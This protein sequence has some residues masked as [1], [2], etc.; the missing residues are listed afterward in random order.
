M[1]LLAKIAI[2]FTGTL[3][4]AGAYTFREG[5]VRVDVDEAQAGGS[6]VHVWVPAAI[7]PMAMHL[8]P[9]K[10]VEHALQQAGPM[11]PTVR[12]VVE[13]LRK[14]PDADLVEVQDGSDHVQI[15]LR[16]GKIH[17][18]VENPQENVHVVCPLAMLE[19]LSR[20]VEA[21]IPGA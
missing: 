14:Y 16:D 8:A 18:D 9:R 11:M 3:V 20:E 10:H 1:L 15:R 17:V 5:T 21:A 6:H 13:G 19:D 2:G 4:A 7:I 12:A